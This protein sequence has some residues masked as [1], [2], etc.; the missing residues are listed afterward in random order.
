V[1]FWEFVVKLD[2][3]GPDFIA[4]YLVPVYAPAKNLAAARG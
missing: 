3:P 2:M 4:D 1:V